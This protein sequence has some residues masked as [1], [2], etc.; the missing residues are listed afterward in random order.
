ME[1]YRFTDGKGVYAAIQTSSMGKK[2]I[3]E[4]FGPIPSGV[5]IEDVVPTFVQPQ[6][7]MYVSSD[8]R[9]NATADTVEKLSVDGSNAEQNQ[10]TGVV[11]VD[12]E[13]ELSLGKY[14]VSMVISEQ[15]KAVV[16]VNAKQKSDV[17]TQVLRNPVKYNYELVSAN[18]SVNYV[19]TVSKE[20]GY[21]SNEANAG[22]GENPD[23]ASSVVSV[24]NVEEVENNNKTWNATVYRN[25]TRSIDCI[26]DADDAL[27][28]QSV[29]IEKCHSNYDDDG[30][31][32][33]VNYSA[34]EN[35]VEIISTE[36]NTLDSPVENNDDH[37]EEDDQDSEENANKNDDNS[38][39]TDEDSADEDSSDEE[40][41]DFLDD[42]NDENVDVK[43][44]KI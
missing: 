26:V 5:L 33:T 17:V 8:N 29:A 23:S 44:I 6:A 1:N 32:V 38:D 34:D 24:S 14:N 40:L 22:E 2:C 18:I 37:L 4:L 3:Y 20:S 43:D 13:G 27:N 25:I 15:W 39:A 28:A 9:Q 21:Q 36:D 31:C 41:E 16:P 7:I 35:D 10:Q 12:R 42:K 11:N 19:K 30:I